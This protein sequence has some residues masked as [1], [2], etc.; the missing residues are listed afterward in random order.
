M[1]N[2]LLDELMQADQ[3]AKVVGNPPLETQVVES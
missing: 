2:E 1:A 3:A